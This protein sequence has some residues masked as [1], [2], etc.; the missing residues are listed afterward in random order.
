PSLIPHPEFDSEHLVLL[1]LHS[2]PDSPVIGLLQLQIITLLTAKNQCAPVQPIWI[3]PG[4]A[5]CI[6]FHVSLD[7]HAKCTVVMHEMCECWRDEGLS[8]DIIGLKK[9]CTE[10]YP[11]Y[12]DPFGVHNYPSRSSA[13]AEKV[14]G[15]LSFAFEMKRAVCAL[16]GVVTYGVH[17]S[18][19]QK[20]PVGDRGEKSLRLWIPMHASTK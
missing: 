12:C 6:G 4:I 3:G 20:V 7:M 19:C 2:T 14:G 15:E 16:F 10:I 17:M 18:T 1:Y 5:Q 11:I 13:E 8:P 9:W